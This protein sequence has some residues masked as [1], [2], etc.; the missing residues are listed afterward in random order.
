MYPVFEAKRYPDI[1]KTYS[2]AFSSDRSGTPQEGGTVGFSWEDSGLHI[3][4]ELVDSCVVEQN[5][6]DDQL[7]YEFGDVFEVFVKP[8]HDDYYWEMYAIPSGN[9]STLFFPRN[10]TG[11]ELNDFL[12]GHDYRSLEVSTEESSKGWNVHLFV[13]ASQLTALGAGWGDGTEWTI[14]CSRYNYNS[15]DLIDPEF[16]MTPPLSE[17]NYHLTGEYALLSLLGNGATCGKRSAETILA[18]S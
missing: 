10:R 18:E 1:G 5:R 15:D 4:A 3:F 7:H 17:T 14:L 12:H 16:S 8:L 9:K 6:E 11:L 13:P 2:L